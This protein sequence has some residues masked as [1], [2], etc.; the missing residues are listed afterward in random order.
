[1]KLI[2]TINPNF[3]PGV[4]GEKKNLWKKFWKYFTSFKFILD[5]RSIKFKTNEKAQLRSD[6]AM[7]EFS[8]EEAKH[9]STKDE[10]QDEE[11]DKEQT[12]ESNKSSKQ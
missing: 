11:E 8:D 4:M 9:Q 3:Q 6:E 7:E 1:M 12:E 10:E 2:K 5:W